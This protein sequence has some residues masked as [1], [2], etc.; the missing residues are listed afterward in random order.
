[1]LISKYRHQG[2]ERGHQRNADGHILSTTFQN[3]A[4]EERNFVPIN[5]TL[6]TGIALISLG[7]FAD[8]SVGLML[9]YTKVWHWEHLWLLYTFLAFAV[10]PWVLGLISVRHLAIVLT[11]DRR[12]VSL[13]MLFGLGWGCGAVL[14]GL[15]LKMVGL[16]LSYAIVMGLTAAVGSCAPLILL[17][18]QVLNTFRGRVIIGGV[19]LVLV[20]VVLC[21]WAG[22]FKDQA[23][24]RHTVRSGQS[25]LESFV[26]GL[27]VAILSGLFSPMLNLS[28]AYGS[29]LAVLA[30]HQG[31]N[32]FL[33][34]NV[35]FAVALSAGSLVNTVYC[36]YLISK[37]QTWNLMFHRSPD[38]LLGLVMGILGPLGTILYGMG[39]SQLGELGAVVGWPIMSSMGILSANFWGAVSGEWSGTGRKP[40]LAMGAAVSVLL[41]AMFILGWANTLG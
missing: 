19:F 5:S 1:L 38:G 21:A 40:A 39:S 22:H 18:G 30:V 6:A 14:Y 13:V 28:F 33:A 4:D 20:G 34:S 17:H 31:T 36:S 12:S 25:K 3:E 8:G 24:A 15:A 32:P 16:A 7:A 29:P 37:R 41:A 11:S 26:L 27:T 2:T 10:I 35:I 23:L 9:K